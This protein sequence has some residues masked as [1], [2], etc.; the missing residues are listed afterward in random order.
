[1]LALAF[2]LSFLIPHTTYLSTL[3]YQ[4]RNFLNN[5]PRQNVNTSDVSHLV[6]LVWSRC[7]EALCRFVRWRTKP[8]QLDV[9]NGEK[10]FRSPSAISFMCW[11][12]WNLAASY[13]TQSTYQLLILLHASEKFK[14]SPVTSSRRIEC[15]QYARNSL[16]VSPTTTS[17]V[18]SL[19]SIQS[20]L[21]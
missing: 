16:C 19:H 12:F 1:M 10:S 6:E 11:H 8:M 9:K 13:S 2:F 14:R 15:K 18:Y 20:Q 21:K 4:T 3:I 7:T 5:L 17:I